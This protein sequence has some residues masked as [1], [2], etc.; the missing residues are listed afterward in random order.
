MELMVKRF[1]T[2][3]PPVGFSTGEKWTAKALLLPFATVAVL[4]PTLTEHAKIPDNSG[5]L[6]FESA[7][8]VQ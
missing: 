8:M 1:E 7:E 3:M 6:V 2:R 5:V 4:Y